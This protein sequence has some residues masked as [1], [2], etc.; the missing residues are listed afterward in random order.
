MKNSLRI[1]LV[2][3]PLLL[4]FALTTSSGISGA[5]SLDQKHAPAAPYL[6]GAYPYLGSDYESR[7]AVVSSVASDA[8]QRFKITKIGIRNNSS[9]PITAVR[10]AWYMSRSADLQPFAPDKKSV[11][12]TGE[13]SRINLPTKIFPRYH[14]AI[15]QI[16][17]SFEDAYKQ[18]R[19]ANAKPSGRYRIEVAAVEV[20]F[21]DGSSWKAD[22]AYPRADESRVSLTKISFARPEPQYCPVTECAWN[23]AFYECTGSSFQVGCYNCFST[24]CN[25][26]CSDPPVC[27]PCN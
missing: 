11:L 21:D 15:N 17:V 12:T 10:L 4:V 9:K 23:G 5:N 16:V 27:P 25:S 14:G 19:S 24:C 7:P 22:Q 3:A 8:K 2:V 1:L 18:L 26:L 20:F 6:V 13:T